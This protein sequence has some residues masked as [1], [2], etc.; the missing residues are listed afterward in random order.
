MLEKNGRA[1]ISFENNEAFATNSV[2][3]NKVLNIP[4]EK[5]NIYG[6][7]ISLGHP[8]GCSGARLIVTLLNGLS[9]TGGKRGIASLCHGVGGGTAVL[10]EMV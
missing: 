1:K 8:I 10:V 4:Y 7:G 5:L 9:R 6:G 3:F 2:L